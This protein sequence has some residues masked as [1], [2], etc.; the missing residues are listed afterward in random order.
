MIGSMP[1][2]ARV[3]TISDGLLLMI[4]KKTQLLIGIL[5]KCVKKQWGIDPTL[6]S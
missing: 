6:D 3:I 4:K 1:G 5:R 2:L